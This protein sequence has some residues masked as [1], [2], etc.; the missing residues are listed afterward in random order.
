MSR[1][2]TWNAG[3]RFEL[4]VGKVKF[5]SFFMRKLIQGLAHAVVGG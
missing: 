2:S 3:V 4:G 1:Q 5:A